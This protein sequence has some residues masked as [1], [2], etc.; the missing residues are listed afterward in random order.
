MY[1]YVCVRALV[2]VY[3]DIQVCAHVYA[4]EGQKLTF[5]F[6]ITHLN[7]FRDMALV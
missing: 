3:V 6:I 5:S 1:V 7:F 4:C 2:Y